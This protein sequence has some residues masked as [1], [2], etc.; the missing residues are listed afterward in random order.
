[1][2]A[3]KKKLEATIPV[4][5]VMKEKAEPR[6]AHILLRGAYDNPGERVERNT[7]A[8]L[9]PLKTKEATPTRMDLAEWFVSPEHPLTARVAV[10]RFW[11]QLFGIGIVKTSEDFGAQG[12]WPSHPELLDYLTV[13]FVEHGCYS[14][15][16]LGTEWI[17]R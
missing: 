6:P 1:M 9:P 3:E 7:P 11:Q 16:V 2:E 12:E 15:G 17:P 10:N 13:S 4:A 5:M 8:F 14:P